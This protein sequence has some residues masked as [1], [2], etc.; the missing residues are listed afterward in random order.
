LVSGV[1]LIVDIVTT[2]VWQEPV[3]AFV[4]SRRQ[5]DLE[6]SFEQ[7]RGEAE[8]QLNAGSSQAQIAV[9]ESST[10]QS[11]DPI[12]RLSFPTLDE[13]YV[14]VEGTSAGELR[15]GPGHYPDTDL[16]GQGGTIGIAGHRT[17]FGAP[18]RDINDLRNGDPIALETAYGRFNY[19]VER[20]QVVDPDALWVLDDTTRER[21]VLTACHPV[22]RASQ[23][24]IVFA[25]RGRAKG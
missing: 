18:F 16:P 20:T 4:T 2:L 9:S 5:S 8:A 11:G 12:G 1:L 10:L 6:D 24:L 17:T 13:S 23:R 7:R 19:S 3:S 15:S 21:L 22:Y 14:V 25:K